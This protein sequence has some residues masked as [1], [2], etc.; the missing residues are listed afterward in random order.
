LLSKFQNSLPKMIKPKVVAK[1]VNAKVVAV[2]KQLLASQGILAVPGDASY[3]GTRE[4]IVRKAAQQQKAEEKAAA[5]AA[6]SKAE[7]AI[8]TMTRTR[9]LRKQE[10]VKRVKARMPRSIKDRKQRV[11]SGLWS[12][13]KVYPL[14]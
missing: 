12:L 6:A 11:M 9:T 3:A 1:E 2:I 4:Q 7:K 14:C 10:R 13:R 8:E 5:Q